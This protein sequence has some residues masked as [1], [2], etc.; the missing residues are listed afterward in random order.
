MYHPGHNRYY[1]R[2]LLEE[3]IL[4]ISCSPLFHS[5]LILAQLQISQVLCFSLICEMQIKVCYH[6]VDN[7]WV[8]RRP[9]IS[10]CLG[11]QLCPDCLVSPSLGIHLLLV[12]PFG[13]SEPAG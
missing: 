13:W 1:F 8:N 4:K 3:F 10:L 5:F 9:M 11:L 6:D 2:I 12:S 7:I